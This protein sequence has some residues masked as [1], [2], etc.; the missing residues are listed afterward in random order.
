M[1]D[2]EIRRVTE[3][4]WPAV[5]DV[6]RITF[7][8]EYTDDD[9]KAFRLTFPF[10]RSL[11]AFDNGRLVGVTAVLPFQLTVPGATSVPMGGLS[12]VGVLPT[13]RRRGIL[14]SLVRS[15]FAD[16]LERGEIVSGLGASEGNIYGR[17]G[18]G[19][20]TSAISFEVER[21][22]AQLLAE[23][24]QSQATDG[25]PA[26]RGSGRISLLGA[27]EAATKLPPLY[28][29]LRVTHPG[30]TDRPDWWWQ[31]QFVDPPYNR[32][33]AGRLYHVVHESHAGAPD[34]YAG[35]RLREN[36]IKE[37]A[38]LEVKV[39]ELWAADPQA[40]QALWQYLLNTDLSRTI[41]CHRGRVDEPLRWLLA[42]ARRFN[43][44]SVYDNLWVRLLDVRQALAAR[45]YSCA[46]RLT[47][48]VSDQFPTRTVGTLRLSVEQAGVPGVECADSTLSP[49]IALDMGCLGAV[50]L[51]GLS[52]ANL[53]AA[54][55]V[56]E[57]RPGSVDLA[58]AMFS[59]GTAPFCGTEF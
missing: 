14:R 27:A 58:D 10:A 32:E 54:G 56:K 59:C 24:S 40:Y 55:R 23:A 17:Y 19:P 20:A 21:P 37:S 4:E 7:G 50:Y 25:A 13:H 6:C 28:E 41:S 12:W 34:G 8:E 1:H 30:A 38:A 9:T 29:R 53:A 52:F 22:Y 26:A 15:Q 43:V 48:R 51:G 47:L 5:L 2:F 39:V 3:D 31:A 33:G 36:W 49:D 16:M 18:Y 42:D 11:G 46:G 57:L 44:T 45:A 35:Y